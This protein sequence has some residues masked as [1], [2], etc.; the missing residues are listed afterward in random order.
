[1]ANERKAWWQWW[2][3]PRTATVGGV[4]PLADVRNLYRDLGLE[5]SSY[6]RFDEPP[7][8]PSAWV[9]ESRSE[10]FIPPS[11]AQGTTARRHVEAGGDAVMTLER[12]DLPRADIPAPSEPV[13]R[14]RA[15]VTGQPLAPSQVVK[16]PEQATSASR[17]SLLNRL[18]SG[19]RQD[20]RTLA[21]VIG[22]VSYTGGVG[23]STLA[24]A[25]GAAF[26][27][28][29][30]RCALVGQTPYS[31]LAYYFG[32][33]DIEGA[34]SGAAIVHYSQAIEGGGKPV[35]LL[36]GDAPTAELI[37]NV[38]HRAS[39]ASV[40]V[41]DMEASP[42]VAEDLPFF[43]MAIV[44]VRPDIN[45][46]VMIERIERALDEAVHRPRYGTWYLLNQFD[47]ARELHVQV[48]EALRK[49][50][51][52]RLLTL[53]LPLD[54]SVQEA[55]ANGQPPQVY[56]AYTPFARAIDEFEAWLEDMIQPDSTSTPP[57]GA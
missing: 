24:A 11:R 19:G 29:N 34:R 40:V 46:L 37:E 48:S 6:Q 30:R 28:L 14:S 18:E 1:M 27:R 35:D 16:A 49:R 41:M 38:R 8:P 9:D 54:N 43:D 52:S 2:R 13:A 44:P 45:A 47:A 55:L 23:K 42:H 56:R 57:G 36:I 10:E 51:G 53:S 3:R 22:L 31:P 4:D 32:G 33:P 5:P 7:P 50:L 39:Q 21:P 20:E 25:L 12:A 17:F 15:A 26:A